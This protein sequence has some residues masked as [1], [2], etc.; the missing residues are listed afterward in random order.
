M[1]YTICCFYSNKVL[2]LFF[3]VAGLA[4][5]NHPYYA[6]SS[7]ILFHFDD[8]FN[9]PGAVF[10]TQFQKYAGIKLVS[11]EPMVYFLL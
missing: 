7:H 2:G 1:L 5:M 6:S 11:T 4:I 10:L 9:M 8:R 3:I